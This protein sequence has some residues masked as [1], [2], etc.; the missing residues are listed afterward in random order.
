M[1]G[2]NV[3][4][5]K[6]DPKQ[7]QGRWGSCFTLLPTDCLSTPLLNFATGCPLTPPLHVAI[8]LSVSEVLTMATVSQKRSRKSMAGTKAHACS[9]LKGG[10]GPVVVSDPSDNEGGSEDG[11]LPTSRPSEKTYAVCQPTASNDDKEEEERGG[12]ERVCLL[13]T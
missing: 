2:D 4:N 11:G 8:W 1:A 12:G 7:I 9:V 13:P 10:V 3:D 6:V 5:V